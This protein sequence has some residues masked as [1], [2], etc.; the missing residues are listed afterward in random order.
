[1]YLVVML[2][3]SLLSILVWSLMAVCGQGCHAKFLGRRNEMSGCAKVL[4]KCSSI[5]RIDIA[6][7]KE[8]LSQV[9]TRATLQ[10]AKRVTWL[11]IGK[12]FNL[13][14]IRSLLLKAI[15]NFLQF[16]KCCWSTLSNAHSAM[17]CT[18][19]KRVAH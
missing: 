15:F 5:C 12:R 18:F 16:D 11:L 9:H 13:L 8:A 17:Q 2:L 7:F 3:F 1:M 6:F 19:G 14:K 10:D 4:L